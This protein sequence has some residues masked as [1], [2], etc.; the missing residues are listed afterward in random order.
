[1]NKSITFN[2][3]CKTIEKAKILQKN[4][5]DYHT[6]DEIFNYSP[7]GELFMIFEWYE[8]AKNVLKN[9]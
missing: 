9:N 8:I 5:G 4:N 7:T 6:A 2:T 3:M 1:M